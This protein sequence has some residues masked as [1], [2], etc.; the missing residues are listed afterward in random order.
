MKERDKQTAKQEEEREFSS[1][2]EYPEGHCE[3]TNEAA[4]T[5]LVHVRCRCLQE[6]KVLKGPAEERN[7]NQQ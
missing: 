3:W 5:G 4:P 6:S 1:I 7:N 2:Q